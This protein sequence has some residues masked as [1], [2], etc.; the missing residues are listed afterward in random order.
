MTT[1]YSL[2][3]GFPEYLPGEQRLYDSV[4]NNIKRTF[5]KY[6]FCPIETPIVERLE[7]LTAKGNQGDNI[8]YGIDRN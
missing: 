8:I 6:G 7:V 5:L 2:P 3:S 4:L 1:N